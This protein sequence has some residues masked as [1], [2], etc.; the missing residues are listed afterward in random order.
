M[1]ITDIKPTKTGRFSVFVNGEFAFS[2]DA[3]TLVKSKIVKGQEI[4]AKSLSELAGESMEAKLRGKA[5][6]L[7]SYRAHGKQEL[8]RKLA[9]N[10]DRE[11]ASSAADE[12][13]RS[14]LINDE[15]F[16]REY[17]KEVSVYKGWG[18]KK[19]R[20]ELRKRGVSE[21]LTE[22]VIDELGL[23]E[24]TQIALVLDKKFKGPYDRKTQKKIFD[25]F[26]R[27]GF[28][29]N[30]ILSAMKEKNEESDDEEIYGD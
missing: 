14:G 2:A 11:A 17:A 15:E 24:Q 13:E 20:Y 8:I 26:Y 4:D 25:Y 18:P 27:M 28:H 12:L 1:T 9:K 16:A 30:E 3:E 21:E 22:K 7:L 19:I 23:D 6:N 5:L 29:S 10:S